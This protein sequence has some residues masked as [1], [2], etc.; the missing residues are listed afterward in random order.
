MKENKIRTARNID[1]TDMFDLLSILTDVEIVQMKTENI[2]RHIA[3]L[4][5]EA[6][7]K[8]RHKERSYENSVKELFKKYFNTEPD[9]A[10]TNAYNIAKKEENV[11]YPKWG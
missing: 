6:R 3:G 4:D 9:T 5:L 7:Q 8:E 11:L 2:I 1:A 10:W